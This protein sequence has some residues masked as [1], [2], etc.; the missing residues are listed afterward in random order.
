MEFLEQDWL[1]GILA[2]RV[3][4]NQEGFSMSSVREPLRSQ[5][6]S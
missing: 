6:R 1:S 3:D 2:G 5:L 4:R